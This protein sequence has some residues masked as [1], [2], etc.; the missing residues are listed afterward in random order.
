MASLYGRVCSTESNSAPSL[1]PVLPD[2][3]LRIPPPCESLTQCPTRR[4]QAGLEVAAAGLWV[5]AAVI[6]FLTNA[7]FVMMRH[8]PMRWFCM[9]RR[10][11]GGSAPPC[12]TPP[13]LNVLVRDVNGRT[14]CIVVAAD[15][16]V[17]EIRAAVAENSAMTVMEVRCG[18]RRLSAH[19][20]QQA[21]PP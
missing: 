16:S 5:T 12:S 2:L 18:G 7:R 11:R 4:G 3:T 6:V 21:V 20:V 15:A 8:R 13:R 9:G 10:G 19:H 14:R 1:S 17:E